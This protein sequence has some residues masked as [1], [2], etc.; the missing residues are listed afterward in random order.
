MN[1]FEFLC[2]GQ[3]AV[4][5]CKDEQRNDVHFSCVGLCAQASW[6]LNPM[7][8]GAEQSIQCFSLHKLNAVNTSVGCN[9]RLGPEDGEKK[10]TK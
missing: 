5:T 8:S 1:E 7:N 10:K 2:A 4:T 6:T 9:A 3:R